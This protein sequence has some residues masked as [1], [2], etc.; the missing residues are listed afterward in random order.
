MLKKPF[1][2]VIKNEILWN[3]NLLV[4]FG[5]FHFSIIPFFVYHI[6]LLVQFFAQS[7]HKQNNIKSLNRRA[8]AK[9]GSCSF[10]CHKLPKIR[11]RKQHTYRLMHTHENGVYAWHLYTLESYLCVGHFHC[12]ISV[13]LLQWPAH[14]WRS[15]RDKPDSWSGGTLSLKVVSLFSFFCSFSSSNITVAV[16]SSLV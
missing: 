15:C 8:W 13:M 4:V 16:F 6:N 5:N 14:T 12:V 9:K 3:A 7:L 2:K 10:Q 1:L 11:W